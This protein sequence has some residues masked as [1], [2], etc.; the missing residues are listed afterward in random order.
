MITPIFKKKFV[1]EVF[2]NIENYLL[3]LFSGNLMILDHEL[4]FL[5]RFYINLLKAIYKMYTNECNTLDQIYDLFSSR[6]IDE[7]F[8]NININTIR[9]IIG[10]PPFTKKEVSRL[11]GL[12][13]EVIFII[14][15]SEFYLQIHDISVHR[16]IQ[17][18]KLLISYTFSLLKLSSLEEAES[19]K[20]SYAI[21][22]SIK[23]LFNMMDERVA[24]TSVEIYS[25][26]Y[27]NNYLCH[28]FKYK[29]SY[30][31]FAYFE[32]AIGKRQDKFRLMRKYR[33]TR[34]Y[35]NIVLINLFYLNCDNFNFLNQILC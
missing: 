17:L 31:A 4:K 27:K 32:N 25:A 5:V 13:V 2:N 10:I 29:D 24:C 26:I 23:D 9:Q 21:Q 33:K 28:S 6:N 20:H 1:I 22:G 12:I 16:S 11:F 19:Y 18:Y 34:V 35:S 14:K 7:Y 30:L 15:Y 8:I 3:N